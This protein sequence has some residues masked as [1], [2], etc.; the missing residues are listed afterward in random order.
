M[1]FMPMSLKGGLDM[2]SF[3]ERYQDNNSPE[4]RKVYFL[5]SNGYPMQRERAAK[6]FKVNEA[7]TVKEIYVGGSSSEVEFVE[8]PNQRFNTVMFEDIN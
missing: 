6:L 1:D 8:Y 7:L 4:G 2:Y 3:G 5:N